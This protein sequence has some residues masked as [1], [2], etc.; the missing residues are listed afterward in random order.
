M[1]HWGTAE[2]RDG[3]DAIEEIAKLPWCNGKV[4]MA[5]NSWLAIV[6]YFIATQRPPHLACIAPLEGATDALR[7][8][9]GRGGILH[10]GFGGAVGSSIIG[11]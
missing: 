5:G 2:G 10:P 7:E 4:A 11:W 8:I 1:R 6:Q 9:V 3:H